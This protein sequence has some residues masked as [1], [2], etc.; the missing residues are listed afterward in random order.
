M[1]PFERELGGY[2]P[3]FLIGTV[4]RPRH[5][6]SCGLGASKVTDEAVSDHEHLRGCQSPTFD[7]HRKAAGLG[8][9]DARIVGCEDEVQQMAK[10]CSFD[11]LVGFEARGIGEYGEVVTAA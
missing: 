7:G 2:R 1:D 4:L 9:Q 8:L 6:Q 3:R 11:A 5:G 10:A